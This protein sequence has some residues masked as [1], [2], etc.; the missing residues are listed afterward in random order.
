MAREK[1]SVIL[2]KGLELQNVLFVPKLNCNLVSFLKL[3]KQL[4]DA[5]T[6]YDNCCVIYNRTSRTLIGAGE[7]R[8][9]IYYYNRL[10]F[11]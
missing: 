5:M 3:S 11:Q 8:E 7:P 9:G 10:D 1:G 6:F 2:D 4:N